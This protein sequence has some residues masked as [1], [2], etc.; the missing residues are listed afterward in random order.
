MEMSKWCRFRIRS[1]T[2][3]FGYILLFFSH[4][5]KASLRSKIIYTWCDSVFVIFWW[6]RRNRAIGGSTPWETTWPTS[7]PR[8]TTKTSKTTWSRCW[9]ITRTSGQRFWESLYHLLAVCS[10]W[11]RAGSVPSKQGSSAKR[12][13]SATPHVMKAGSAVVKKS[14]NVKIMGQEK[15]Q[16]EAVLTNIPIL[17]SFLRV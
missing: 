16:S 3:T 11:K 1:I 14:P 7:S 4:W 6:N 2:D 17:I 13:T 12:E 9:S 15:A 10:E 5:I 8:K